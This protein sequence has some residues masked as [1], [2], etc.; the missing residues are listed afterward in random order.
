MPVVAMAHPAEELIRQITEDLISALK[1]PTAKT[2]SEFVRTKIDQEVLPHIDF[3]TMTK[4]S[5]GGK[6]WKAAS[7]EQ[8]KELV[9]EFKELL[10]GTYTSA[11]DQYSGQKLEIK[12]HTPAKDDDKIAVIKTVFDDASVKVPVDYKLK[13]T[14]K[15]R[16]TWLVY[17]IEV[18]KVSLVKA[19]QAEF[20]SEIKKSGVDGLIQVL[21]DKNSK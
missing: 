11:L 12:P 20:S 1:N 15:D 9:G 5:V 7:K 21:R 8:R 19:Y 10:L 4:L 13:T 3:V 2:D 6:Q 14:K 17:D 16:E 18:E